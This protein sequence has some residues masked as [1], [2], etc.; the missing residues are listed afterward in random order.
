MQSRHSNTQAHMCTSTHT[1]SR[2]H[3][4]YTHAHTNTHT[5]GRRRR[6]CYVLAF[7]HFA[8]VAA[9]KRQNES[10]KHFDL[11]MDERYRYGEHITHHT[12]T[13]T[14]IFNHNFFARLFSHFA[15]YFCNSKRVCNSNTFAILPYDVA[16]SISVTTRNTTPCRCYRCLFFFFCLLYFICVFYTR[17]AYCIHIVN[18]E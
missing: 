10:D 11:N 15:F 1:I 4:Q 12:S 13:H 2:T 14:H 16:N 8:N 6:C 18:A 9:E 3:I 7:R 17:V 5:Y